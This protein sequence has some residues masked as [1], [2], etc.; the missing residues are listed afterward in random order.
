VIHLDTSFLVDLLREAQNRTHGPAARF[1][2][3]HP[4]EEL[5]IST[6]VLCEL[7]AGAELSKDPTAERRRVARLCENLNISYLDQRFPAVY[8]RLFAD[9]KRSGQKISSMDLLIATAA[10]IDSAPLLTR[11]L[12]DFNR[13]PGLDVKSY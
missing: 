4:D 10:I 6:P 5:W 11:N 9:L 1:L 12:R 2:E 8:G 13:I 3:E 7:A